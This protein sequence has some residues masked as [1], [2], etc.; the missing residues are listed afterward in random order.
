MNKKYLKK[1][2][3]EQLHGKIKTREIVLAHNLTNKLNHC[4]FTFRFLNNNEK[5]YF[6]FYCIS[7]N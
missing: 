4:C 6:E 7:A 1:E 3:G 2:G 5:S